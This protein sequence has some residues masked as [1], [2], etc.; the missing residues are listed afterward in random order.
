MRL[1]ETLWN[2]THEKVISDGHN[3]GVGVHL[4]WYH[5]ENA[6]WKTSQQ[7]MTVNK[8]E[9]LQEDIHETALANIWSTQWTSHRRT[10]SNVCYKRGLHP[11]SNPITCCSSAPLGNEFEALCFFLA[12]TCISLVSVLH[13]LVPVEIPNSFATGTNGLPSQVLFLRLW[14][15][16]T[17]P[18]IS[19]HFEKLSRKPSVVR[20]LASD[21]VSPG[22]AFVPLC[23]PLCT[24]A[25]STR[26]QH[27]W[28]LQLAKEGK[29]C[30][31]YLWA[32]QLHIYLGV[33]KKKST[34]CGYGPVFHVL[35][36][37]T[38]HRRAETISNW[39]SSV[40]T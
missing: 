18:K 27:R 22:I 31:H 19:L 8:M 25:E 11:N 29:R 35:Y 17:S 37:E 1:G 7:L 34:I 13:H 24:Q 40:P 33:D 12:F 38:S 5:N 14:N 9:Y 28:H 32:V 20:A 39:L 26:P 21:L 30:C 16:T 3:S 23:P 10:W 2:Y 4:I 36:E 15:K 6:T